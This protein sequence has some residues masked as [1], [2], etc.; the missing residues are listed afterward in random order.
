MSFEDSDP[1]IRNPEGDIPGTRFR[2]IIGSRV[3]S[4][5]V[6]MP[7][8]LDIDEEEKGDLEKSLQAA[9]CLAI[10]PYQILDKYKNK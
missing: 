9:V 6:G 4:I 3:V 5:T 2:I 7:F 1:D 10:K 8:R